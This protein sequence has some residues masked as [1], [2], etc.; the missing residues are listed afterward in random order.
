MTI[1]SRRRGA[2]APRVVATPLLVLVFAT[3]AICTSCG[4]CNKKAPPKSEPTLPAA[5]APAKETVL[6]SSP[7][8]VVR[9]P[10]TPKPPKIDG[11]ITEFNEAGGTGWFVGVDGLEAHPASEAR[12]MWDDKN[13]YLGLYAADQDIEVHVTK[14]DE[15]VWTDDSFR[16]RLATLDDPKHPYAIDI[17]AKGVVA[18]AKR[19]DNGKM[20]LSWESHID[21]KVGID[22]DQT[23]NDSKDD[24]EEWTVEAALPWSS[25]GVV[26]KPGTIISIDV[27]RCD[28]PKGG[29]TV[30]GTFGQAPDGSLVG[31]LELLP[32]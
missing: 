16:M 32:P 27:K 7:T 10:H 26:P 19:L 3:T 12:F 13:L 23:I 2:R 22:E 1:L 29:A 11:E 9:V 30:C 4:G 31:R 6:P 8:N 24:D 20:D 28:T 17:N 25:I 14:H 5:Q 21:L 18:D 15:P